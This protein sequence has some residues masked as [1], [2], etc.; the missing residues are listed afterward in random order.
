V[1]G[2]SCSPSP[3]GILALPPLRAVRGRMAVMMRLRESAPRELYSS[4]SD[5]LGFR[6]FER[7]STIGILVGSGIAAGPWALIPFTLIAVLRMRWISQ[8]IAS[9][10]ALAAIG[11]VEYWRLPIRL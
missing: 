5:M 10:I 7:V 11:A 8:T 6:F 3:V 1:D 9:C 4:V 2:S